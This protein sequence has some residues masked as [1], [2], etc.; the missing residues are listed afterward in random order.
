MT[1]DKRRALITGG[2]RGIGKE[3]VRL[4]AEAGHR[5][6]FTYRPNDESK[7][8]AESLL[9]ALPGRDV[10]ILPFEQG[11]LES[12]AELIRKVGPIDIVIHNAAVGTKTVEYVAPTPRTQDEAFFRINSLGPMWLTDDLLPGMKERGYGKIVFISSVDGGITH[13]PKFRQADGMSKAALAFLGRQLAATVAHDPIDVFTVCPGGTDT[14]MFQASTLDKL[15]AEE[16][17]RLE[18]SLPGGRLIRPE[19][20]AALCLQLCRE[21]SRIMRG[22]VIDAS[23]GLGVRPD[24][25]M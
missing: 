2:G 8:R 7:R 12:H 16:R 23:L 11:D 13:F 10:G 5:V 15:S 6:V 1:M 21:E 4:F 18:A 9:Q 24:S 20:I 25:M 22:A 3:L 17:A 14:P 19:E